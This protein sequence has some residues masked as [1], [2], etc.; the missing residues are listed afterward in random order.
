MKYLFACVIIALLCNTAEARRYRT[1]CVKPDQKRCFIINQ[2]Y[3]DV[4]GSLIRSQLTELQDAVGITE[5]GNIK[6]EGVKIDQQ[7]NDIDYLEIFEQN[8]DYIQL[9]CSL[10]KSTL[11]GSA[12]GTSKVKIRDDKIGEV[13]FH[14]SQEIDVGTQQTKISL[15]LLDQLRVQGVGVKGCLGEILLKEH[16]ENQT[17]VETRFMF[18]VHVCV[19]ACFPRLVSKIAW[20]QA[21]Q[22]NCQSQHRFEQLVRSYVAK[23]EGGNILS[24]I[25]NILSTQNLMPKEV[26]F[27]EAS[28]R[29]QKDEHGKWVPDV[30]TK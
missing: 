14:V 11:E 22:I 29:L 27:D 7:G 4:L 20:N 25:M 8:W 28:I 19:P 1:Q 2:P 6:L 5:E 18:H 9:T 10:K 26:G 21:C 3:D 15:N 12:K 24:N 16:G 13:V 23:Y 30:S 17:W